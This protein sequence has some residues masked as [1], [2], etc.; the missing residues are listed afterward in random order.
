MGPTELIHCFCSSFMGVLCRAVPPAPQRCTVVATPAIGAPF[1]ARLPLSHQDCV[2]LK[3]M[4]KWPC[5]HSELQHF[6]SQCKSG[7][8][9]GFIFHLTSR[10]Q[11]SLLISFLD[12][13]SVLAALLMCYRFQAQPKYPVN[14]VYCSTR[15]TGI[16]SEPLCYASLQHITYL[17]SIT[18]QQAVVV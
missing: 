2:K 16:T 7:N 12:C 10:K 18:W 9:H 1:W 8:L 11:E 15:V 17:L 14:W 6:R 5:L 13:S 4:L 3:A